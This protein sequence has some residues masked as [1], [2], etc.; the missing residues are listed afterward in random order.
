M[1]SEDD[2]DDDTSAAPVEED[3]RA[4]AESSVAIDANAEN[5][6]KPLV[7][8]SKLRL[9]PFELL[10]L[11]LDEDFTFDFGSRPCIPLN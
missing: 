4:S 1:V 6:I 2:D 3:F 5:P 8:G 9:M 7:L 10:L 11:P